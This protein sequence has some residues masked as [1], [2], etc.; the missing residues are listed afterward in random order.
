MPFREILPFDERISAGKMCKVLKRELP[1]HEINGKGRTVLL[2]ELQLNIHISRASRFSLFIFQTQ[3]D[4][5][6]ETGGKA[7]SEVFSDRR[8]YRRF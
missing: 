2:L 1:L 3:I 8:A 6:A 7:R 4:E 5:L